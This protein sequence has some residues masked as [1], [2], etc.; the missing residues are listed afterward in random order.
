MMKIS[1]TDRET[2]TKLLRLEYNKKTKLVKYRNKW[3][4]PEVIYNKGYQDANIKQKCN[5]CEK[6]LTN[7]QW[8]CDKCQIENQRM[9]S[10]IVGEISRIFK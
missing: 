2:G 3:I 6:P 4:K 5:D 9:M 8:R 7:Y 10:E 1:F